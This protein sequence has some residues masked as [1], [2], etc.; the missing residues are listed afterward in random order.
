V[1]WD[2]CCYAFVYDSTKKFPP[3][4][5]SFKKKKR[6]KEKKKKNKK[7]KQSPLKLL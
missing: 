1:T 4:S 6:K 3:V 5:S 2:H 7:A